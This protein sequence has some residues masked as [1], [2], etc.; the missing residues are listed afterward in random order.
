MAT[1]LLVEDDEVL[2]ETLRY[3]LEQSGFCVATAGD[4]I[5]GLTM[6]RQLR[7]DLIL[8]DV[9]LP[10]L[11]G[12]SVC[13]A[14]AREMAV[15]IML[16]TALNDEANIVAGLELGATDYVIKPFSMRELLAR[17][18]ALLRWHERQA[19]WPAAQEL[20][21]GPL[22]LDR[23]SRLAWNGDQSLTLS[24]KEFDLLAYMMLHAGAA[25]SRDTLLEQV[26]GSDFVGSYRT[27]DVHVRW[28]REK[29]EPS[30]SEPLLIQTV[31]GVGYRLGAPTEEAG[32]PH[33]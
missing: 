17:I 5:A 13:S 19:H 24:P 30:P 23:R 8:L 26:W 15:P 4:G 9:M 3:N 25:L 33:A 22:R 16:L 20:A 31:R 1:L 6:A 28:L 14:L 21:I 32:A 29:I 2:L 27:I 18:R 12:F 10:K 7:P 11:D